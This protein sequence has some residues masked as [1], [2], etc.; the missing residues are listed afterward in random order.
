MVV[1]LLQ[2]VDGSTALHLAAYAGALSLI[3]LLLLNGANPDLRD[4]DGRLPLHW[5]TKPQSIKPITELLKVIRIFVTI[6]D[7]HCLR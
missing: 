4:C 1:Q 6:P 5:A 3:E 2:A 7:L